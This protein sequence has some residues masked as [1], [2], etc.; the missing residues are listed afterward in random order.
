L[1]GRESGA[2]T[3][4]PRTCRKQVQVGAGKSKKANDEEV[5]KPAQI[6]QKKKNKAR[7]KIVLGEHLGTYVVIFR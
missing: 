4:S 5:W 2:L 3:L 6:Q 7:P 1:E